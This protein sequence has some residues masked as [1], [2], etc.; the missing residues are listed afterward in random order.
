[1]PPNTRNAVNVTVWVPGDDA[2]YMSGLL[3]EVAVAVEAAVGAYAP[4]GIDQ[5]VE[6]LEYS[7][8]FGDAIAQAMEH[9]AQTG[10]PN[11]AVI[12]SNLACDDLNRAEELL[13]VDL[14]ENGDFV[15]VVPVGDYNEEWATY[16]YGDPDSAADN[17]D[18]VTV[19][20][21][22]DSDTAMREVGPWAADVA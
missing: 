15:V 16:L 6:Q 10:T 20:E 17:V 14:P 1:M 3:G 5:K 12:I 7:G 11:L 22:G 9:A 8:D 18:V 21:L 19:A 13:L 2:F 4:L